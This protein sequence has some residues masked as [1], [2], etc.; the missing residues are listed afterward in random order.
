MLDRHSFHIALVVFAGYSIGAFP[1][2]AATIHVPADQSTIQGGIDAASEGDT[3]V[4]APGT[5]YE[6]EIDFMGKAIRVTGTD[7]LDPS[8]VDATVVDGQ[9]R[10]SVFYF[11]GGESRESVLSGVTV[12]EG[13]GA[14]WPNNRGGGVT[15]RDD[16]SPTIEYCLIRAN[17]AGGG[18]GIYAKEST[19][20]VVK[21][22]VEDNGSEFRGGGIYCHMAPMLIENCSV[23]GNTSAFGGGINCNDCAPTIRDC[24]V[25]ENSATTGGGGIVA[26]VS[27]PNISN[28]MIT[29]NNGGRSG[30]GFSFAQSNPLIVNCTIADNV[31]STSGAAAYVSASSPAFLNCILWNSSSGEFDI[32]SGSPTAEFCNIRGGFRGEGNIEANPRFADAEGSDYHLTGRSPCIDTGTLEG[33]PDTDF[34]GDARPLGDGYDIG[35]DEFEGE[36]CDLEV[37]LSNYPASVEREG[38]LLFTATAINGCGDP[39]TFD[40]VVLS[41]TGP[42]SL[43]KIL[44][45]GVP[46]TVEESVSKDLGPVVPPGAPLGTYTVELILYGD[47][48]AVDSD[49][50]DVDVTG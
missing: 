44:F 39:L 33:A 14:G 26:G 4:V 25:S 12:Q 3:V 38:R 6:Y 42:A 34:E 49:A 21:C 19:P 9:R 8:V 50:F 41:I 16:A 20:R 40:R 15:C 37:E 2:H 23:T 24:L 1:A 28:C 45:D 30:G 22:R 47:G 5:Y 36:I 10:G 31:V 46:F 32:A 18:G 17:W 7:P 43:E 48:K 11:H 13:L 35:A 29:Q 27:N